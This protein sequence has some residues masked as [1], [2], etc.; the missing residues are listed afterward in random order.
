MILSLPAKCKRCGTQP[1]KGAFGNHDLSHCSVQPGPGAARPG[2][3]AVSGILCPPGG[4]LHRGAA[5]RG[6]RPAGPGRRGYPVR[7]LPCGADGGQRPGGPESRRY[8][9]A[10]R[11]RACGRCPL[12]TSSIWSVP[13]MWCISILP[14]GRMCPPSPSGCPLRRWQSP[15][16]RT[17][18]FCSPTAPMWSTWRRQSSWRQASSGC[19]AG[20]GCPSPAARK[21]PSEPGLKP[22]WN[23]IRNA[24]KETGEGSKKLPS[25]LLQKQREFSRKVCYNLKKLEPTRGR[26]GPWPGI[27]L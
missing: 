24:N 18:A 16:W 23:K 27:D 3:A 17:T 25:F 21:L 20:P 19:G 22:G 13:T 4:C 12:R 2:G 6:G 11:R 1:G 9:A 8:P 5:A 15:C 26:R 7:A 10:A 14:P